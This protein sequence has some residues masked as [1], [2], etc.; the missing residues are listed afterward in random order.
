VQAQLAATRRQHTDVQLCA[1]NVGVKFRLA[2]ADKESMTKANEFRCV[3][4]AIISNAIGSPNHSRAC[5][6]LAALRGAE[7]DMQ[8]PGV[9]IRF[10]QHSTPEA[11]AEA[12]E[13]VLSR[14]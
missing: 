9:L 10:G 3:I 11:Q 2:D 14:V 5:I 8:S 1:A 7:R 13:N 4:E 6:A 12:V